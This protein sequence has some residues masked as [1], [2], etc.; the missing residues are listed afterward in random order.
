MMMPLDS[1]KAHTPQRRGNKMNYLATADYWFKDVPG[2]MA[3]VAWDIAQLMQKQGHQVTLFCRRKHPT[4]PAIS[5]ANGIKIIKYSFPKTLSLDPFKIYKQ[6]NAAFEACKEYLSQTRFDIIHIHNPQEGAALYRLFGS[7]AKYVYT[8][9]SPI[10]MEQEIIW[11]S[12]GVPGK[13]KLLLGK[14]TLRNLEGGLL[15]KVQKIH[16]LSQYTKSKLEEFYGVGHKV[17][18]IPH[19]CRED[20]I[21]TQSLSEAR[22]KLGWPV[23]TR[24]F[25]SIRRLEWR[26]GLDVAIKAVAPLLIKYPDVYFMIAGAGS[27]EQNLKQL[28]VSLGVSDKIQ[29]LG[30]VSDAMLKNCYEAADLF[31]LPT[32][33]LEC[34]GLPVLEAF[35]YGLPVISTD[36]AALPELMKPILPQWIVPAGD[37]EA[38]RCKLEAYVN[39]RLVL[40]DNENVTKYVFENYSKQAIVPR[41][42]QLLEQNS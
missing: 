14:G 22:R 17:I 2:G 21:R 26:M 33:A 3:R 19:W 6:I 1:M 40:S 9:H 20:F 29:F 27:L 35:A 16:T 41:L 25:F 31:V 5:E 23:A 15:R 11:G 34:F 36:A 37:A 7:A 39:H 32:R 8:V 12:Q 30:R 4:D 38:L 24:I 13:I 42:C 18:V 10:V 28:C